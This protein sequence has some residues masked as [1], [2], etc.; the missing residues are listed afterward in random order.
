[1]LYGRFVQILTNIIFYINIIKLLFAQYFCTV[2]NHAT[3]ASS[4]AL[5]FDHISSHV[6]STFG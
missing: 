2:Y 3:V 4:R 6:R 5:S 1:M